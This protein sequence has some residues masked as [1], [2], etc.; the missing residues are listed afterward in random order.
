MPE[1]IEYLAS[2]S[3]AIFSGP[4]KELSII[5]DQC[6]AYSGEITT[7]TAYQTFLEFK[8]GKEITK[9]A[10]QL[11]GDL[12]S[13]GSNAMTLRCYI[14][15]TIVTFVSMIS[16]NFDWEHLSFLLPPFSNF[17][18]EAKATGGTPKLTVMFTGTI[19]GNK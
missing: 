11:A 3:N 2:G 6:Y 1:G 10:M 17:K 8:T 12:Y 14:N 5:E 15:E 19:H 4:G 13:L 16:T 18:V 7:S 9:G